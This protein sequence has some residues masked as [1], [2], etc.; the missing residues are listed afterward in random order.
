MGAALSVFR[1]TDDGDFERILSDL[2]EQ[3]RTA[4]LRLSDIKLREKKTSI[5]FLVYSVLLY[6][7]YG[8]AYFVYLRQPTDDSHLW[9]V[10]F[11]PLVL[12]PI[13]LYFLNRLIALWYRR[14]KVNEDEHLVNL[15]AK[16]KLKVSDMGDDMDGSNLPQ[17]HVLTK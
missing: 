8:V 14:K 2:D 11:V 5:V 17:A 15:R 1:R 6:L 4:E 13:I 12:I 10:K 3:I 7:L 9:L 16:Q